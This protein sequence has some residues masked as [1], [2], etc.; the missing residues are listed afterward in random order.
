LAE[1]PPVEAIRVLHIDDEQDQLDFMKIFMAKID[2]SMQIESVST[3][4]D[5]V[6]RLGEA[7]FDC[8]ICDYQM[9][10]MN[11]VE[12][13]RLIR[14]KHS[15]PLI[16][17]MSQGSEEV[18]EAAF[19]AE[20]DGYI[21]KEA[22]PGHYRVLSKSIRQT[23]EKRRLEELYRTV[24]ERGMD[25]FSITDDRK[26]L[27]V[28]QAMA[29]LVGVASP[30]DLIG[31]DLKRWFTDEYRDRIAADAA[32]MIPGERHPF[33]YGATIRRADGQI[34]RIES[35][36]A[37]I[38][39]VGKPVSLAFA[40]DVT[41]RHRVEE[42]LRR[43]YEQRSRLLDEERMMKTKFAALNRSAVEL[44]RAKGAEEIHAIALRTVEES[45]GYSWCGVGVVEG[46]AIRYQSYRGVDISVDWVLPLGG[47]GITVRA[48]RL[49][50]TQLVPD[51]RLDP[52]Y[53]T[54]RPDEVI[55]SELAVP[56][57]VD[58]EVKAVINVEG[59]SAN[60]FSEEDGV[61]V[62]TLAAHV[63]SALTRLREVEELEASVAEKTQELLEAGKMIAAGRV[64]ATVAHDLKGPLQMIRNMVYLTRQRPERS[65]EFLGRIVSAV[66]Y[67]NEMIESVRQATKEAPI[68]LAEA[69]LGSVVRVGAEVAEGTPNITVSVDVEDLERQMVDTGKIRRVVENLVRNAVDAMP[70]G[71]T[72]TVSARREDGAVT[73]R[74][75]DTGK[76]IPPEFLPKLFRAFESTK[77]QG[78][79]LGLSFCKQTVEAHGG[80]IEVDSEQGKGTTFTIRLPAR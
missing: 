15:T 42:E 68:Q 27:Y 56:V 76:G 46:D 43:A 58:G 38:S 80:T 59:G 65:V 22:N 77:P 1:T 75:S 49:K 28:N 53:V 48:V 3:A 47:P 45:L 20:V 51:V 5:A 17:Y 29:D 33:L 66:D 7:P 6:K 36:V 18:A 9:P 21:R 52:D 16:I 41:E 54:S 69:D 34:R 74:V 26:I 37:I 61:L 12:L 72:V 13:A 78:M 11:G 60:A 57:V 44:S 35:S 50:A 39:L 71:G 55:L 19:A 4:A 64:A 24:V 40:R 67:A 32:G 14:S 63:S 10:E 2:P 30:H 73:I 8:I 79:G 31:Q 70:G 25:P 23:V 62:E